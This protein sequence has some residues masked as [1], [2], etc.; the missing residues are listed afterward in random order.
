MTDHTLHSTLLP[1]PEA[2]LPYQEMGSNSKRMSGNEH[3]VTHKIE[4]YTMQKGTKFRVYHMY[5]YK[6]TG[7]L[8]AWYEAFLT[9]KSATWLLHIM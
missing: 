5:C 1:A 4:Q 8:P 9:V 2:P 7:T 6:S 3:L